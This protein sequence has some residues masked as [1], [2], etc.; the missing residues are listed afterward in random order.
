MTVER[1]L[2]SAAY[3]LNGRAERSSSDPVQRNDFLTRIEEVEESIRRV[4]SSPT[5]PTSTRAFDATSPPL[6][7]ARSTQSEHN[8]PAS[9]GNPGYSGPAQVV[10]TYSHLHALQ[11][12]EGYVVE[13]GATEFVAR[14]IGI[15]AGAS[16]EEEDAIIPLV[17]VSPHDTATL[18]EGT[19]FRWVIGFQRS[20]YGAKKRVS[21]I[22]FRD[23]P[24]TTKGDLAAGAAWAEHVL[25]SFR[26]EVDGHAR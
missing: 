8:L 17:E 19:I 22:V 2:S 4:L 15:T 26:I 24:V 25:R 1:D 10:G 21:R 18:R 11:E 14:L 7:E 6:A 9:P 12:W 23:L 13:I 16:I 20:P 3:P 5:A